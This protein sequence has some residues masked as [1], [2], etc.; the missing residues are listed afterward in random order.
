MDST[1]DG[2]GE[3]SDTL[4]RDKVKRRKSRRILKGRQSNTARL[5]QQIAKATEQGPGWQP[6]RRCLVIKPYSEFKVRLAKAGEPVSY[7][8]AC[9]ECRLYESRRREAHPRSRGQSGRGDPKEEVE[10]DDQ[11]E[12]MEEDD[13]EE[14]DVET[15]AD[16]P[17]EENNQQVKRSALST[18][19]S[20]T[21]P[22]P[23]ISSITV[24]VVWKMQSRLP[25]AREMWQ[26]MLDTGLEDE[27]IPR[28]RIMLPRGMADYQFRDL[29]RQ[30]FKLEEMGGQILTLQIRPSFTNISKTRWAE[31]WEEL[32]GEQGSDSVVFMTLRRRRED[33]ELLEGKQVW[34]DDE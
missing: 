29:I 10:H 32:A 34:G 31:V 2:H 30:E 33:E 4:H 24:T 8:K 7:Q 11:E 26:H 6:C 28:A 3:Q 5:A 9:T 25:Q 13:Q 17:A 1:E 23:P 15:E 14:Q 20:A 12:E 21:A 22:T 27:L 19:A 16:T 18:P